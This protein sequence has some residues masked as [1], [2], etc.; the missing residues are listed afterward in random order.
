MPSAKYCARYWD[1]AVVLV[2]ETEPIAVGKLR[3]QESQCWSSSPKA[4]MPVIR[5][6]TFLFKSKSQKQTNIPLKGTQA[7]GVSYHLQE[8][9]F[10]FYPG[11]QLMDKA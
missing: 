3:T 7:D 11:L 4:S 2:R 9:V 5:E 10:F 1:I 8:S 6:E